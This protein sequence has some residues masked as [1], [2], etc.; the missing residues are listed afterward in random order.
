MTALDT[1]QPHCRA[2]ELRVRVILSLP[3]YRVSTVLTT[4]LCLALAD[5]TT[6]PRHSNRIAELPD[7]FA[8]LVNLEVL[9]LSANEFK[10]FPEVTPCPP[11]P[12]VLRLI[13]L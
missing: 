12:V 7:E 2:A 6:L 9:N 8:S 1:P 13:E 4:F 11:T 3:L 5:P 10:D